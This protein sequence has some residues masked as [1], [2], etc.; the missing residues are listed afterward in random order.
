MALE[1]SVAA[2]AQRLQAQSDERARYQQQVQH[3]QAVAKDRETQRLDEQR[4]REEIAAQKLNDVRQARVEAERLSLTAERRD[5]LAQQIE[6]DTINRRLDR[7]AAENRAAAAEQQYLDARQSAVDN[8]VPVAGQAT[9]AAAPAS[10][11]TYT[12]YIAERDARLQ[13]RIIQDQN[14][15]NASERAFARSQN[16]VNAFRVDPSIVGDNTGRGGLVDFNA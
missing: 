11:Q 5:N 10:S 3:D 7:E 14:Q 9:T 15:A 2:S 6:D 8:A 16:S 1:I 12:D 4:R 13:A